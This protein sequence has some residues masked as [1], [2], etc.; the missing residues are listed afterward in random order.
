MGPSCSTLSSRRLLRTLH[1]RARDNNLDAHRVGRQH[2]TV[3]EPLHGLLVYGAH[4]RRGK[5]PRRDQLGVRLIRDATEPVDRRELLLVEVAR[6]ARE[7][8]EV[9]AECYAV[10][11]DK[12]DRFTTSP[13]GWIVSTSMPGA[14]FDRTTW[15][16]DV[17][18]SKE[19]LLR[20]SVCQAAFVHEYVHYVQFLTSTIG[21]IILLET[22]RLAVYAGASLDGKEPVRFE[23]QLDLY[24]TL[25]SAQKWRLERT[26]A[27]KQFENL[28]LDLDFALR[29]NLVPCGPVPTSVI[30]RQLTG[31]GRASSRA[32]QDFPHIVDLRDG[33]PFL[34]VPITD[35]LLFENM[36]R[37]VQRNYLIVNNA[38]PDLAASV[39]PVD[40]LRS[41]PLGDILYTC[42]HDHFAHR[43]AAGVAAKWTI[44]LCQL[45][46][47]CRHPGLAMARIIERAEGL[48]YPSLDVL[49]DYLRKDSFFAGEFNVPPIQPVLDELV[50][51][52]AS[53]FRP[54]HAFHLQGLATA[55]AAANNAVSDP[56]ETFADQFVTWKTV[57]AWLR[58]F[59]C[60]RVVCANGV[61]DEIDGIALVQPW[62][63]ILSMA[64][65]LLAP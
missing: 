23:H 48:R 5:A 33:H 58:R 38:Q 6:L 20:D 44:V 37:Q 49:L 39:K 52:W 55:I 17:P 53:A 62:H 3:E 51:K 13:I 31:H 42:V 54:A 22:I 50:H 60:P 21:R 36:A 40:D 43:G 56:W 15:S 47:G 32:V 19:D 59:G 16:I 29:L 65:K 26:Q 4:L 9:F 2:A 28:Q 57:V 8:S 12:R 34:A 64:A 1:E 11:L 24:E 10:S 46:L 18:F 30:R 27:A 7:A 14:S 25:E 35:R 41:E 45:A 63:D 61:L